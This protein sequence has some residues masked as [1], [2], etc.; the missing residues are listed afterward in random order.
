MKAVACVQHTGRPSIHA[1]RPSGCETN[2]VSVLLFLVEIH[3]GWIETAY[4]SE[5][6]HSRGER[7]RTGRRMA[8]G[9]SCSRERMPTLPALQERHPGGARPGTAWRVDD[10]GR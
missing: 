3:S 2:S 4:E 9:A 10:A 7:Q 6:R 1:A 5:I 8:V